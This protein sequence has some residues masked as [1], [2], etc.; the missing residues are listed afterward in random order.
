MYAYASMWARK[1]GADARARPVV[2]DLTRSVVA[3]LTRPVA[4]GRLW[5][6]SGVDLTLV[7]CS[8]RCWCGASD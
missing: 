2:V 5:T 3:D 8:V 4:F 7:W 1:E 6:F